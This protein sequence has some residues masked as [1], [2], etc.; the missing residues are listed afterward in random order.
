MLK[1]WLVVAALCGAL[2]GLELSPAAA[3]QYPPAGGLL[4]VS[5][6]TVV[7]GQTVRLT[8]EDAGPG[9]VWTFTFESDPVYLGTATAN[10]AGVVIF[11]ATIPADAT[12]GTHT[13]VATSDTGEQR[14][15]TVTVVA[16]DGATAGQPADGGLA[17]TGRNLGRMARVGVLLLALGAALLAARRRI[18]DRQSQPDQA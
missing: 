3:Q 10:D 16:A 1:R 18:A 2:V 11:D 12:L 6:T 9:S 17:L 13:I 14:S 15:V 5:D 4:T 7:P 8:A